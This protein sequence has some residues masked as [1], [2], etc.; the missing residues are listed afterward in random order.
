[1]I[2][3]ISAL[4]AGAFLLTGCNKPRAN[5][6]DTSSATHIMCVDSFDKEA[7]TIA[8]YFDTAVKTV[9]KVQ[10]ISDVSPSSIDESIELLGLCHSLLK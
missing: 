5:A 9:P 2:Q 8:I 4:L 3:M 1:M 6:Y 10:Y 7:S